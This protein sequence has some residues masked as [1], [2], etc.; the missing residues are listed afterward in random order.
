MTNPIS[1]LS[2]YP[3]MHTNG[4]ATDVLRENYRKPTQNLRPFAL[5]GA[6]HE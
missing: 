2:K 3:L 1:S 6:L 4:V 5:I